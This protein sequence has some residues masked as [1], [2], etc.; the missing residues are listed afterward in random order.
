MRIRNI[1]H[2][3][4]PR[5][6]KRQ[7]AGWLVGVS[8][9]ALLVIGWVSILLSGRVD[10]K[11]PVAVAQ[12]FVEQVLSDNSPQAYQLTTAQYH[13][14]VS[15]QDFSTN[16]VPSLQHQLASS[17]LQLVENAANPRNASQDQAVFNIP[18]DGQIK[19]AHVLVLLYKEHDE[20]H[21]QAVRASVGLV[22]A[23]KSK[24]QR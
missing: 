12:S 16:F 9:V 11:D 8:V 24:Q 13:Q 17:K 7:L 15:L 23:S 19:D 22:S 1:P 4:V 18:G 5:L 14:R 2:V 3:T 20:W 10:Y 6:T 21:V